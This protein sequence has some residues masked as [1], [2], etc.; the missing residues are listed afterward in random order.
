MRGRPGRAQL[1]RQQGNPGG[2][3]GRK[4]LL[5]ALAFGLSLDKSQF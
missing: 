2:F 1:P 4:L 3:I 5:A